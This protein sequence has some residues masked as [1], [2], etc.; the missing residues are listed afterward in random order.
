MALKKPSPHFTVGGAVT[1]NVTLATAPEVA[2]NV[3]LNSTTALDFANASTGLTLTATTAGST[4]TV[5]TQLTDGTSTRPVTA[6]GAGT[7]AL[8]RATGN[9]YDGTTTVSGTC[10]LLAQNTSGSA[11]GTGAV[12]VEAGAALGGTGTISG[13]VTLADTA[14]LA[15]T[16][17][18]TP[19]LHDSLSLGSTLTLPGTSTLTIT[20]AGTEPTP[21]SYLLLTTTG[22][23]TGNLPALTLPSGWTG[24]LQKTNTDKDLT[25]V[26]TATKPIHTWRQLHFGD[27]RETGTSANDADPDNDGLNNLMEYAL[28]CSPT[29]PTG[30][31]RPKS[32]ITTIDGSNY[33]Y[34]QYTRPD[35]APADVVYDVQS[36]ADLQTWASNSVVTLSTAVENGVATVRVRATQDLSSSQR[37][38]RLKVLAP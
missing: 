4:L 22:G 15:F 27:W 8:T 10:T 29:V 19:N 26:L 2:G 37:F 21:G 23:I 20:G 28:G 38:L 36:S 25:L 13:A 5:A 7:L 3:T 35:P 33:V 1:G 11:T 14:Q 30:G 9:T 32:S 17:S 34:I 24:S 16:L 12:T 31:S 6:S 18:T